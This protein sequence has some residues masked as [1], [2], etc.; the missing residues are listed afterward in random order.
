MDKTYKLDIDHELEQ[1]IEKYNID[2]HYPAYRSSRRACDFIKNWIDEL[3]DTEGTFLFISMDGYALQLIRGWITGDNISTIKL[4]A[5]EDLY[6]YI[7]KLQNA[8]K[9]YIVSYTRTTE[10]LHWLWRHDLRAESVYDVLENHHIYTQMEYYRF[11]TPMVDSAELDID[12]IIKGS[13][14]DG[15]Y[16]VLYEYCFQKQRLMHAASMEDK[17]RITEKLFFLAIC[18]RNFTEA[19]RILKTMQYNAGHEK[20]WN[21][22]EGLLDRI[23]KTL[24]SKNQSHIIIYWLDSLDYQHA[25]KVEYLQERRDHS[26][27]FNN[28]Y[29]VTPYTNPTLRA[30]FCGKR[31][32]DDLGYRTV[33]IGSD[34]SPLLKDIIEQGY[35]FSVL[36]DTFR[37]YFDKRY[38]QKYECTVM[39]PCSEVFWN[40]AVQMINEENPTVYLAH[41]L[42]EM[43]S[44]RL[45]VRR[46]SFE[47]KFI[48]D[49]EEIDRQIREL[50]VQLRF[51]DEMLG[52][53]HYRVYMSDHGSSLM[54]D[55]LHILFQ[56]YHAAWKNR[57]IDKLFCYLDFAGIMHQL[58]TGGTIDATAWNRQYV[59]AQDVD[60][61]NGGRLKKWLKNLGLER[62][63]FCMAYKGVVTS[64]YA[65]LRFKTGDELLHKWSD[66]PYVPVL[67]MNNDQKDSELF[68]E[69]REMAGGFPEEVDSDPK[70]IDASNIHTI[71]ENVKKTVLEAT[72]LV[73]E[74]LGGYEDGSIALLEGGNHSRQ[75]YAVLTEENR[76]KIGGI[77][78]RDTQCLCKSLGYRVYQSGEVLPDTIKAVLVSVHDNLTDMKSEIQEIYS[79]LEIIDIYEYWKGCGYPFARDFWYGLEEDYEIADLLEVKEDGGNVATL[80]EELQKTV[81]SPSG[82]TDIPRERSRLYRDLRDEAGR[83]SKKTSL[84]A[85]PYIN[86]IYENVK[87]TIKIAS[88]LLNEKFAGYADGSIALRSGGYHTK[89]IC[90]IL[91]RENR[92]KIGGIIDAYDQCAC[93]NLGY[94]IYKTDE[95]L[96]ENIKAVLLSSYLNLDELKTEADRL[97]SNQEIIDIYRYW[98]DCGYCF[99]KDF[100]YGTENDWKAGI[101]EQEQH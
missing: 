73:N 47:R 35:Q 4:S 75:L 61:Y 78:D 87:K 88:K 1:I 30:M 2:A 5:L 96:P 94:K 55:K 59:P 43:H 22:I 40:L 8:D 46:N 36:G 80:F 81:E 69:L 71:Y 92:N 53:S 21:E 44:P 90:A 95:A 98:E 26:L 6:E 77:I 15:S 64:E 37:R 3:S 56:V 67:G 74:M 100:W 86:V 51:Y 16:S 28:A 76:K 42:V 13:F 33:H 63:P 34:N 25:E 54:P 11:F 31:Q 79:N 50:D 72:K 84:D 9:I 82:N 99:W 41:A 101:I 19:G 70:F 97:Y 23:R 93:E 66:G 20:C 32:V 27:Y 12:D 62:L 24:A 52:D 10:I 49:P 39:T 60:F 29:T 91:T 83:F 18:M 68:E 85:G 45:G 7:V 58:L 17:R 38:Y 57:E 89:Q 14:F 65:Y 48:W